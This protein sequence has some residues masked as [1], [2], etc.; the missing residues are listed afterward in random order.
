MASGLSHAHIISRL[1]HYTNLTIDRDVRAGGHGNLRAI[2]FSF[3]PAS[4][5]LDATRGSPL[6][7][8]EHA[9]ALAAT[10]VSCLKRA[11]GQN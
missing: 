4:L 9:M 10:K 7:Q 1:Y 6:T 5:D 11:M 3:S 8:L 2:T